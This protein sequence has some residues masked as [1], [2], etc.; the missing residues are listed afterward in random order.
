MEVAR[1]EVAFMF[2]VHP[3]HITAFGG[4]AVDETTALDHQ[5]SLA[6]P[7]ETKGP[8]RSAMKA[9]L[10]IIIGTVLIAVLAMLYKFML[11]KHVPESRHEAMIL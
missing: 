3:S 7:S 11:S 8:A 6:P 9:N 1:L 4:G 10:L 5:R 2:G